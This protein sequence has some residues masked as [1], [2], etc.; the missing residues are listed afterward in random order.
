MKIEFTSL[1][2]EPLVYFLLHSGVFVVGLGLIFFFLGMWF[3]A[4]V[5]G[6]HRR[7][8]LRLREEGDSM[9]E[10]LAD[11]KRKL[12]ERAVRPATAALSAPPATLLTEVLPSVNDIF[13]ERAASP[14]KAPLVDTSPPLAEFPPAIP[15]VPFLPEPLL[16]EDAV[17]EK[18]KTP[19]I[20]PKLPLPNSLP[21]VK[22]EVPSED[23]VEPFSFLLEDDVSEPTAS[24]DA[25]PE[26]PPHP[27]TLSS[28]IAPTTAVKTTEAA[29]PPSVI[30]ENDPALGIIF[31]ESPADPDDL[32]RVQGISPALQNRLQELGVYKLQQIAA[33][34]HTQV[35][36]YSRRLAFKDRIERERWVEQA[37]RLMVGELV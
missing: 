26:E 34:N 17:P 3:G 22:K 5:W 29:A 20:K 14:A 21:L 27:S 8:N 1:Q 37:R 33:W 19:P 9:R 31:K 11:L 4:L 16:I 32:T 6:R 28:I 30:P 23:S 2:S 36:E 12:A 7:Q 15:S 13:P 24:E 18:I 10:E 35:R 25:A